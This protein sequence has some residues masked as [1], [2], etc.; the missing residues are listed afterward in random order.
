[1]LNA[2]DM[3][4]ELEDWR[5]VMR[6]HAALEEFLDLR[7]Y[8]NEAIQRGEQ[9]LQAARNAQTD[10]GVASFAHNVALIYQNRGE[11]TKARQLY[12]ESLEIEKK[13]GNQSVIVATL[14]NLALIAERQGDLEEAER[15]CREALS[16]YKRLGSPDA[17]DARESLE[18]IRAGS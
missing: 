10:E 12:D 1:M 4:Y 16:I 9:A 11:L 13:L 6:I 2:L 8:W 17:K 3:A 14:Y 18:R 7:G 5:S 15:L